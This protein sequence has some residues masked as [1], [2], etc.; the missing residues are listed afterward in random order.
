MTQDHWPSLAQHSG[1]RT[2]TSTCCWTRTFPSAVIILW[3]VAASTKNR[4]RSWDPAR[5]HRVHGPSA[6]QSRLGCGRRGSSIWWSHGHQELHAAAVPLA[7]SPGVA[8]AEAGA[9]QGLL[10]SCGF[11]LLLEASQTRALSLAWLWSPGHSHWPP[12]LHLST[13]LTRGH[14]QRQPPAQPCLRGL[15]SLCQ[16]RP[17]PRARSAH[18]QLLPIAVGSDRLSFHPSP[19]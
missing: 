17:P 19:A 5:S 16:P 7:V 10:T 6:P 13:P 8:V 11:P 4:R 12:H 9:C 2:V 18:C 15:N 3:P 1:E 14:A